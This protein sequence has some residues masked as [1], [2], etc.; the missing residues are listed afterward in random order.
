RLEAT[1]M[2]LVRLKP[3]SKIPVSQKGWQNASPKAAEFLPGENVGVQL[4][5][6]SG[7]IV[8]IDLD[9]PEARAL[10]GLE[11]FF[12]HLPAFRRTSLPPDEPGHRL[13]VCR[14][15]PD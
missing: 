7:H 2:Q 11:C 4:G 5:S 1:G 12:G 8:D 9:I 3:G 13:V 15:A 14:D 10:A 6:K